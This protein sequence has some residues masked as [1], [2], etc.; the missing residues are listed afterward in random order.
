MKNGDAPRVLAVSS[1]GGHWV[2]LL[3]LRPA[4]AGLV[5]AYVCVRPE[6]LNISA[7]TQPGGNYVAAM[8][9]EFIFHGDHVR[10]KLSAPGMNEIIVKTPARGVKFPA[11]GVAVTLSW[12]PSAARAFVS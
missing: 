4:F 2:Q 9:E 7:E 12:E 3:R 5:V 10:V 6:Y 11:K 1:G 8:I